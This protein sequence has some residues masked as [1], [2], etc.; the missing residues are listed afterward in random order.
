MLEPFGEGVAPAFTHSTSLGGLQ[1]ASG[2][3]SGHAVG[4]TMSL[5]MSNDLEAGL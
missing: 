5:F 4:G 1:A 3:T 2:A